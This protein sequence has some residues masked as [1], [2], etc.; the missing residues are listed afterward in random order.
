MN[1]VK[2]LLFIPL[3][4]SACAPNVKVIARYP[5][6]QEKST[7]IFNSKLLGSALKKQLTYYS[8]GKIK[9]ETNFSKKILSMESFFHIIQTAVMRLRENINLISE[10]E[11]GNGPIKITS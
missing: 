4:L 5:N 1:T 11:N 7:E 8:N 10:M 2:I 6:S 9:T 3:L